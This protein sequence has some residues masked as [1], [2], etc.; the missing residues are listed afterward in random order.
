MGIKNQAE[1]KINQSQNQHPNQNP[2][3]LLIMA[4]EVQEQIGAE[5]N[6]ANKCIAYDDTGTV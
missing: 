2:K 3:L 5:V 6:D 4:K 1:V